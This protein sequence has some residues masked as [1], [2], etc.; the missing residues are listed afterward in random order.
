VTVII[1]S[2]APLLAMMV[3]A[4]GMP[5]PTVMP[6]T[7]PSMPAPTVSASPPSPTSEPSA[8]PTAVPSASPTAAPS[9]TALPSPS[10]T[11]VP[12]PTAGT[13]V[14]RNYYFL[15]DSEGNP[16]LVPVLRT[17]PQTVAVAAAAVRTLVEGPT[18]EEKAASPPIQTTVPAATRF[19]GVSIKAGVATVDLSHEFEEGGGSL[20]V[21]ARLAQVVFTLTQFTTIDRVTFELDGVPVTLF[22]PEGIVLDEPVGRSNFHD[23]LLPAIFVDRPAW[24]AALPLPGRVTGLAN[25]FEATLRLAILDRE[26]RSLVGRTVMAT[27]G[28]GCWGTFDATLPY[29]VASAQ[30][31]S[32]RAWEDSAKDGQPIH[33]R[34]YPI[35]LLPAS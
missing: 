4:C 21:R 23:E 33:A 29:V 31:G 34:V 12:S 13:I 9:P 7:G 24:R 10:S 28:M 15:A 19:L 22:S 32:L 18:A 2:A 20:S 27:C 14:I 35:W 5:P 6:S 1:K 25:T 11:S 17:V 26:G 16:G 8:S 30:W 3:L